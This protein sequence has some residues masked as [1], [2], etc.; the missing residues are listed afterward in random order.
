MTPVNVSLTEGPEVQILEP[1]KFS[2]SQKLSPG[3]KPKQSPEAYVKLKL[4]ETPLSV[5]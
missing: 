5:D 2:P 1:L 3:V 4:Q